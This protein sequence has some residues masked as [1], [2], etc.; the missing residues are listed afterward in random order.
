MGLYASV[1]LPRLIDLAMR[2]PALRRERARW[3]PR[4]TGRVIEVGVGS[5]LN[6]P[7]YGPGV[8]RVDAIDP[9]SALWHLA[10]RRRAQA[11]MPVAF[12]PG[13]AEALPF[14]DRAFDTAVLTWTLCS[15]PDPVRAIREIRRVLRPQG[16]LIFV[17]HGRAPEPGV[18][19]WQARITPLW[20]RVAGGCELGRDIPSIL[21]AGGFE[22]AELETAYLDGPR[23]FVYLYRG[24]AAP[25]S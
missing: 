4:A 10:R 22:P 24:I 12:T 1:I 13:S 23:P 8:D 5:G 25:V 6:L 20:K 19:R 2:N 15:I 7:H 11:R 21:T 16:R 17:E 9:S 18:Q 3:I 14:D